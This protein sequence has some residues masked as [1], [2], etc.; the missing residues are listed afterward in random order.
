MPEKDKIAG[1]LFCNGYNCAQSVFCAY[2][3]DF[4]IDFKQGAKLASSFGGGMG[5]L[6]EVC[7]AV[8]AMFMIAG[9]KFG[10]D[11][12]NDGEIKNLHY[13]LIRK[14]AE[15]FK[16]KHGSIIC[17]DLLNG[18][19]SGGVPEKRDDGYYKKRPCQKYVE[20]AAKIIQKEIEK[21]H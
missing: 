14:L 10:Y 11:N 4:G 8:C 17:K 3:E 12:N 5:R 2:C 13:E 19:E 9:L 20:T 7:G 16:K 1:E 15:E 18:A 6:R 21:T